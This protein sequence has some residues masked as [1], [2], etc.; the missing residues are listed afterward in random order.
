MIDYE[1]TKSQPISRTRT[2]PWERGG[3]IPLHDP[4]SG[5]PCVILLD[6]FGSARLD[7][8]TKKSDFD[9]W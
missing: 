8:G 2:V 5:K 7:N 4:I 3:E 9:I 1:E 6:D